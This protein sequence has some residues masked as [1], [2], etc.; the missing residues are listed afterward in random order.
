MKIHYSIL[1]QWSDKD[2]CYIA[3][4]PEFGVHANTHGETYE[5]ALRNAKEVLGLLIEKTEFLPVPQT[6]EIARATV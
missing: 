3:S 2:E 1:I 6:Y 5:E 4:L